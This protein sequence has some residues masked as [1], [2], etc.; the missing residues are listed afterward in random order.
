M[1]NKLSYA[2]TLSTGDKK[3]T[4][5]I[6][7]IRIC[8]RWRVKRQRAQLYNKVN[9]GITKDSS[10]EIEGLL[11]REG[12]KRGGRLDSYVMFRRG[13]PLCSPTWK[14]SNWAS[15]SVRSMMTCIALFCIE[16]RWMMISEYSGRLEDEIPLLLMARAKNRSRF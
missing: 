11:K 13:S 1:K 14:A 4:M 12:K 16:E 3:G 10:D 5:L 6:V 7:V 15:P 8:C 2:K 9:A